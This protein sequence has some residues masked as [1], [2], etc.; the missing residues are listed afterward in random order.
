M[1]LYVAPTGRKSFRIKFRFGGKELLLTIGAVPEV[2]L[3]AARARCDQVRVQ[4]GRG[5]DPRTCEIV[6]TGKACP[7]ENVA[8]QWH[9]HSESPSSPTGS[10]S[11][12]QLNMKLPSL[13]PTTLTSKPASD[14]DVF[15]VNSEPA[16]IVI[17]V[18]LRSQ[19]RAYL[20]INWTYRG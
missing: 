18:P 3:D 1:H 2:S 9:A 5:E 17:A 12:T 19:V 8:R 7:F 6:Q 15:T 4:L 11:E 16:N 14:G 10:M 20:N 13:C